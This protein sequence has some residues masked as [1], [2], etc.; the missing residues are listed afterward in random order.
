MNEI[1]AMQADLQ[2][3]RK[4]RDDAGRVIAELESALAVLARYSDQGGPPLDD[5]QIP[6]SE[7]PHVTPASVVAEGPAAVALTAAELM[8]AGPLWRLLPEL[9]REILASGTKIGGA[10]PVSNLSTILSRNKQKLGLV[11]DKRRG[12]ALVSRVSAHDGLSSGAELGLMA[13]KG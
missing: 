8:R 4:I 6:L 12:W 3:H 10:D 1:A 2:R 11:A 7:K 9:C 5:V 13:Q